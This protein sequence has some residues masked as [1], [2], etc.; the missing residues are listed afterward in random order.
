MATTR[1][2]TRKITV[3]VFVPGRSGYLTEIDGSLESMQALVEGPIEHVNL[4][5][6]SAGQPMLSSLVAICNEEGTLRKLPK[7]RWGLVG[8]FFVVRLS[9]DRYVSLI[10]KDIELLKE[11][12]RIIA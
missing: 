5:W 9:K 4:P 8:K 7:N 6:G 2:I 10:Q 3:K 11:M 12:D 1:K